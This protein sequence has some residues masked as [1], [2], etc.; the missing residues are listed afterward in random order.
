MVWPRPRMHSRSTTVFGYAN[1]ILSWSFSSRC[2]NDSVV[3][4]TVAS[5]TRRLPMKGI[6]YGKCSNQRSFLKPL[7]LTSRVEYCCQRRHQHER[8]REDPRIRQWGKGYQERYSS[9]FEQK[10]IIEEQKLLVDKAYESLHEKNK[11][12]MD[13]IT[14]AKRIQTALVT[15]ERYI[16]HQLERLMKK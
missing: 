14:Y 5:F 9:I 16:N 2:A 12:V 4:G 1:M 13:S 7:L 8:T 11:E 10:K 15:S 3:N 6:N